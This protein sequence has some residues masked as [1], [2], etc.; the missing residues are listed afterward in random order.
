MGCF[1]A[2]GDM[3]CGM[4]EDLMSCPADCN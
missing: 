3:F 4:A 1:D 2:C